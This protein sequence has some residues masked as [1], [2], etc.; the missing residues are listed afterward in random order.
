MAKLVII[1]ESPWITKHIRGVL[2]AAG[3]EVY[4]AEDGDQGL[5]LINRVNPELILLEVILPGKDGFEI[6][7]SLSRENAGIKIIAMISGRVVYADHYLN[8]MKCLGV[9][10]TLKKPFRDRYLV[11]SVETLLHNDEEELTEFTDVLPGDA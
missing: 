2:E 11:D 8:A 1:E 5:E 9:E 4:A 10:L 6:V 3:H 7:T